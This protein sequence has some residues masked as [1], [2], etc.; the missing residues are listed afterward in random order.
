[1]IS[2]ML[3]DDNPTFLASIRQFLATVAQ[4]RVVGEARDGLE[5]LELAKTLRPDLML[6]DVAM[7]HMNGLDVARSMQSWPQA[8]RIVFLSMH[9]S[10]AYREAARNVGALA[11]VGK[12]DFVAELLPIISGLVTTSPG[13]GAKA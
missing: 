9:D 13:N 6:L 5:A 10:T 11:F 1:M 4:A 3:V 8:P 7:P 12:A 2:I